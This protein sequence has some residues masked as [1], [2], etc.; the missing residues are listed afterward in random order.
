M[1]TRA[2][3]IG[4]I[5]EFNDVED[6]GDGAFKALMQYDDGRSQLLFINVLDDYVVFSSPFAH[7]VDVTG[8]KA[9][10]L[11]DS[12]FGVARLGDYFTL[13]AAQLIE[14]IDE[15]ELIGIGN[16]V[17]GRADMMEENIGGDRF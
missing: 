13:R 3:V 6:L 9:I 12:V 15:S 16:A 7:F 4:R 1:A 5:R 8:S 2:E 11:N 10:D 17:A 14:D